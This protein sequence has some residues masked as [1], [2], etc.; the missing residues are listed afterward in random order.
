MKRI[1][2]FAIL[3]LLAYA[4]WGQIQYPYILNP[5]TVAPSGSCSGPQIQ[6]LG[7]NGSIYSCNNGTW[8]IASGG[9]TGTVTS[10]T[11]T[12]NQIDVATGT[13]TPVISLDASLILPTG[14]ALSTPTSGVITNL[15]GTCTAC[16]ANAVTN[17]LTLNNSNSGAASGATYNGSS[18]VTLSANTLGAGSLGNANAW[19]ST[20]AITGSGAASVSPLN[21]NG[22][23]FTGGSA[24]TT[25]PCL[26]VK[27]SSASDGNLATTGQGIMVNMN[28]GWTGYLIAAQI[29]G[30]S[31]VF[32]VG[33]GGVVTAAGF[34]TLA[35][36][37]V[38]AAKYASVTNCAV[39]SASPAACGSAA[40]GA[41][42]IPTTTTSYTVNTTAAQTASRIFLFPMSFA[43]NLPSS[44]TCV[45]PAVTSAPTISAIVNATSFTIAL[46]STTGQTCWSYFIIN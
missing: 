19:T 24:T 10:V 42:V 29:N 32:S 34:T 17:A 5:P 3:W 18:A 4:A 44:P 9:G 38:T 14:A 33:N 21:V 22:S 35:G 43:S 30:A 46:P 37:T 23:C 7:S 1:L 8:A 11:G 13:T 40:A 6:V 27:G 12:A 25:Y 16:T 26:Y 15:T 20:Q 2:A 31:P 45:A 39:N 28:S 36:D 41:V